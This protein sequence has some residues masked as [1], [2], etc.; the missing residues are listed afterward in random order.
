[1]AIKKKRV[2]ITGI[3]GFVGSHLAD[4][5]LENEKIFEVHGTVRYHLS[6]QDHIRHILDKLKIHN[7]DYFDS[8]STYKLIKEIKPDTLTKGE[9]YKNITDIVGYGFVKSYGGS[10]KIIKSG[11]KIS[12]THLLKK[13]SL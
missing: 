13:T 10:V 9:D 3:T 4:Y 7:C 12:T 1:M 6:R 2:L 8:K 5:I 11:K